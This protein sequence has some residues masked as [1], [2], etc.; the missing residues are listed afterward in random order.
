M[1]PVC[2]SL[3]IWAC[4]LLGAGCS[5]GLR[6]GARDALRQSIATAY[7][8]HSFADVEML[9][10]TFHVQAGGRHTQRA[11]TW[12]PGTDTVVFEAGEGRQPTIYR[13]EY[14]STTPPEELRQIDAWFI[15]DRYWLLFPLQIAWDRTARVSDTGPAL[16][17]IRKVPA[18]RVVVTY[19]PEGGYT[20]GDVY[21][22]FIDG[23]KRLV[24]WI[25]RRGGAP[26]PTR[27][28]TWEDH[29]WA[30]PLLVALDRHG[31]DDGFRVW[32][33]D[34]AV[35]MKGSDRWMEAD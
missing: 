1:S 20:P 35:K 31:P 24:E 32:F 19:P 29:R 27:I 6:L 15:N 9:R 17:P 4:V 13:R 14:L 7:G 2:R 30:G 33:T 25:Y 3:A 28:T 10:Y 11:W 21:E 8:I 18:Q 5:G 34:V 26:E 22:I 12:S 16:T 23:Q